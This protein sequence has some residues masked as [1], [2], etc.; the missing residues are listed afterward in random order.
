[1][2]R[3]YTIKFVL[4]VFV[5][6]L[7]SCED[8]K[9]T[10]EQLDRDKIMA[11]EDQL[12]NNRWAISD[13]TVSVALDAKAIPLLA[14]VADENGIVHPGIYDSYAIFGNND[15]QLK[16]TLMFNRD[17]ILMDTA[18]QTNFNRIAG[19]YVLSTSQIRVN[20]DSS[21]KINFDYV[22]NE[23]QNTILFSATSAYSEELIAAINTR[24]VNSILAGRPDDLANGVVELITNNE[25]VSEGIERFLYEII[26]SKIEEITQSPE[27]LSESLARILV[28]KL[29]E[30]DW[31]ELLYN[32][33]LDFLNDL[34][35]QDPEQRATELA[36]RMADK[37]SASLTQNDIYEVLLPLLE[38]F[39]NETLPVLA[40][41]IAAVVYEKIATELSEENLYD[42]IIPLWEQFSSAD[43]TSVA[44][45]ADTLAA[46]ASARFFNAD[47]LTE[48]LQPL[49]QSIEDTPTLKLSNLAQDI[50]DDTLIPSIDSL[51][52]AFPALELNPD[53]T[54]VKPIITS[55]LTAI[56]AK[57]GT[58]TVE[59]LSAEL[60]NGIINILDLVLQK[61]FEKAIF[62]LQ[63]IPADQA[64]TVIASWI[65][66]LI[67]MVEQP[68]VDFITEKLDEILLQFESE[69]AA[70]ELSTLIHTKLIE[71]FSEENLYNLFLPLVEKFQEADLERITKVITKIIGELG[72]IPDDLTEEDLIAAL[73]PLLGELIGKIDPDDT[74]QKLVDLL[75]N[76][77][78]VDQ[79]EGNVLKQVLRMKLYELQG[80]LVGSVNS[81][82]EIVVII[83]QK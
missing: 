56:K 68:V 71:L 35:A 32:K 59:E 55:L 60:A 42:R 48:K 44:E 23:Q 45:T 83:K 10:A 20:P 64:A 7:L 25:K 22:N 58:S 74:T 76:N 40:S 37:I 29:S 65:T 1:M 49:V 24:I 73:S 70:L 77:D 66:N 53:W 75:L 57:L 33:I 14:R 69:K 17:E 31:E 36:Q 81:I 47:T 72:L 62:S 3:V 26:H 67:E 6:A 18:N 50:I 30:V 19:Y 28:K 82:N 16:N 63:E 12:R 52:E 46:V 80:R 41:Q 38:N 13:L 43:S 39:E 61:A 15:R 79:L 34:Q 4:F 8:E 11:V 5:F 51:N 27:E 21:R 9:R 2:K 54:T 78:L